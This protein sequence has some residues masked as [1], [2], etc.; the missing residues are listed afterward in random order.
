MTAT[1]SVPL[2][3]SG[4]TRP[5]V[6]LSFSPLQQDG[7][8]FLVSSCKDGNPMLREWTGDWL[9]T[10]IGHKGAVWST[11]I[12]QDTSLAATGSADFTA[13]VWDTFS[14]KYLHS[15]P[16]NHIVR[17]VALTPNPTKLVTGG[18]EKKVRIFDLTKPEADPIFLSDTS[19]T[20][21]EG[22]VKSVVAVS[23]TL[24]ATAAEDG[25]VKWWDI[26]APGPSWTLNLGAPVTSM[27]L[28][29]GRPILVVTAGNN[30]SFQ[31]AL[32]PTGPSVTVQLAYQP[33]SASMHPLL[34]DR[35]VA[36]STTD[37]WVHVHDPDGREVDVLKGHHGPVHCVAY[38]P[39][40]EMYASGS[41]DGTIR[42][43]QNTPGKTYG[44]WQGA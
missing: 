5:V 44:L 19:G 3:A 2:V 21:H 18:Q 39:D 20:A 42:L 13:K 15:F 31:Q 6:H 29:A 14:G 10:F 35:F 12:S 17:T 43:W 36:G 40:G 8:Y 7:T 4:H 11:K 26:R 23:D 22:T 27:E 1:R 32:T 41:E 30:V 33:S 28:T 24:V 9:G 38:C 37:P 34:G 16:H 25:Y